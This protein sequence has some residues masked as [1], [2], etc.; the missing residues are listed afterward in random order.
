MLNRLAPRPH[1]PDRETPETYAE[2]EYRE[3]EYQV[4]LM[5]EAGVSLTLPRVLDLGCGLGG[6]T[7]YLAERGAGYLLGMDLLERNVRAARNFAATRG[8][9]NAEFVAGDAVSIPLRA[10]S[11]DLIVSTDTFEHFARPEAALAEMT[12]VLRPGGK[13]VAVFG[14]F[15]SPLGSHLYETIFVPWCHVLFSR[16]CLAEAVR[17]I[18]R[19]RAIGHGPDIAAEEMKRAEEQIAYYDHEVNRMTLRRFRRAVRGERGLAVRAWEKRTP[20]RLRPLTHL[21]SVPGLDELLTGLL[22]MVAERVR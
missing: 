4:C 17:E 10:A 20:P 8:A 21:L 13:L 14:P 11:F 2:W 1:F 22:V 18:A 5:E 9:R 7:V 16:D 3:A 19:R 6:K 12:R 15:A